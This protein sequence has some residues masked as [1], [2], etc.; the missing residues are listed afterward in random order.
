MKSLESFEPKKIK[1]LNAIKGGGWNYTGGC[2]D[3]HRDD[4]CVNGNYFVSNGNGTYSRP[5]QCE[6]N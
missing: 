1:N 2:T 3:G 6:I 4:M 5:K